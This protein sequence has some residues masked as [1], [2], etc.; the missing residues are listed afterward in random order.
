[1]ASVTLSQK[2]YVTSVI[3]R[4]T[5]NV[6]DDY[7]NEII[8]IGGALSG[9]VVLGEATG[10][11]PT[12]YPYYNW[13]K[14]YGQI[15][16]AGSTIT[17]WCTADAVGTTDLSVNG[18]TSIQILNG[19]Y[20]IT[21]SNSYVTTAE[22]TNALNQYANTNT[23]PNGATFVF[24]PTPSQ[25][26]V[27]SS[28]TYTITATLGGAG[29]ITGSGTCTIYVVRPAVIVTLNSSFEK[30]YEY[31]FSSITIKTNALSSTT[32]SGATTFL[33][34]YTSPTSYQ[35]ITNL[36][37]NGQY[38][39]V[40]ISSGYSNGLSSV[41]NLKVIPV[42]ANP[43]SL[44][45]PVN[46][47]WQ[48]VFNMLNV[49]KS[50]DVSIVS[51]TL[52]LDGSVI[53]EDDSYV[54]SEVRTYSIKTTC[55]DSNGLTSSPITFILYVVDEVEVL[56]FPPLSTYFKGT[57][58]G[59]NYEVMTGA[60]VSAIA[61]TIK[62]DYQ[63]VSSVVAGYAQ[64][65]IS[66]GA[67]IGTIYDMPKGVRYA[68]QYGLLNAFLFKFGKY[69]KV[70]NV[71][72][73]QLPNDENATFDT[74]VN[75]ARLQP[76]CETSDFSDFYFE[77]PMLLYYK[78]AG[79]THALTYQLHFLPKQSETQKI[80]LGYNFIESLI[81]NDGTDTIRNVYT[82]AG[83][84]SKFQNTAPLGNLDIGASVNTSISGNKVILNVT[85]A[86]LAGKKSWAIVNGAGT[87]LLAYNMVDPFTNVND[88]NATLYFNF[89]HERG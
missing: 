67:I 49:Q 89:G 81:N 8:T 77:S 19:S 31:N 78:D 55:T 5:A 7:K 42:I 64:E 83:T 41:F 10:Y 87:L 70:T 23:I 51:K 15:V 37:E 72:T 61:N 32:P 34:K 54:F 75:N 22:V 26:N 62:I 52:R 71:V 47:S 2:T 30:N 14:S 73:G 85:G 50:S 40:G 57:S 9:T 25:I 74:Q 12:G 76:A 46:T 39:I 58:F 69:T 68:N 33:A 4:F 16:Q 38:I 45:A 59:H 63:F 44:E 1:M 24:S 21:T 82:Y 43:T 53:L 18:D 84:Y 17:A 29:G 3:G 27:N 80:I 28:Q 20:T 65:R 48:D 6:D 56:G 79:N 88:N 60:D 36:T 66:N 11:A 86:N 13:S 35:G